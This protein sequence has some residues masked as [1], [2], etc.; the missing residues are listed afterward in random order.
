[1]VRVPVARERMKQK[2][3]T[4]S[5]STIV[6]ILL[7]AIAGFVSSGPAFAKPAAI[8]VD[9]ETGAILEAKRPDHRHY[10]AS[11]TKLMTL[12]LLF[13]ALERG[14]V[15][16]ETGF[17]VSKRAAGQPASR[18]GL[19]R[20]ETISVRDAILALVVKSA[21]D[22]ATVVAEGLGGKEYKFA[23]KM[24]AKARALG[25]TRTTFMN[26]S[27]L[28]NA[29][30]VS[31]VRDM[32]RLARAILRDF[33]Q[34]YPFFATQSFVYKGTVYRGH[35]TLVGKLDGVD[36]LK[37]GYIRASK[38]NLVSSAKRDGRRVIAVL[39]GAPSPKMRDR[40][41][42]WLLN[43]G[44]KLVRLARATAP[45]PPPEKPIVVAGSPWAIQVGAFTSLRSAYSALRNSL[46]HIP[47][48]VAQAKAIVV[49]VEQGAGGLY[50]ARFVGVSAHEAKRACRILAKK[51]LDCDV[52]RH[53]P[54]TES[55]PFPG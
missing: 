28:P 24:T 53:S 19:R 29:N 11:L 52:V 30:Q 38:F 51:D 20:G 48:I 54:D 8:I 6:V 12:Y 49:P 18:L 34:Y 21:N 1:M 35:N 46:D 3:L 16:M 50:R 2:I 39:F 36:G 27:G 47:G 5:K 13:E 32:A 33:P 10:P 43:R 15:T 22:V 9:A 23:K 25:M 41:M 44:L 7:A 45:A 42:A 37:T 26:A 17:T 14:K 55:L 31:T 4:L 40:E